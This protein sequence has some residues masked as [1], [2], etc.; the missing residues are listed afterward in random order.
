MRPGTQ[1]RTGP[2]RTEPREFS[3]RD[4]EGNL[5]TFGTYDGE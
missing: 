1:T 2:T 5:W 4:P 3:V